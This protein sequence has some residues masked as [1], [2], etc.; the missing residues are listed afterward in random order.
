MAPKSLYMNDK[1]IMKSIYYKI[2]DTVTVD[3]F[4]SVLKRSSLAERRP[5]DDPDCVKGMLE[6]ANLIVTARDG[7]EL[8]GIARSVTDFNYCCYLSDIA[9]DKHYQNSGIGRRMG[10][11]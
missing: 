3:E 6:H 9:V 4:I 1:P 8:V 5:V 7:A 2:N 10:A 11:R